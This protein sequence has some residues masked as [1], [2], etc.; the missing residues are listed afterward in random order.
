[1]SGNGK[2]TFGNGEYQACVMCLR[3]TGRMR[4]DKNGRPYWICLCSRTFLHD[5]LG[6]AGVELLAALT[7]FVPLEELRAFA[8]AQG[9]AAGLPHMSAAL[10]AFEANRGDQGQ[11]PAAAETKGQA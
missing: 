6:F 11:V 9:D 5:P 8:E 4:H 10:R 7:K 1:M 3:Q 2:G